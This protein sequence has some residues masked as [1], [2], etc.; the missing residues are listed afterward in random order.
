[1]ALTNENPPAGGA[2]GL[3]DDAF[4]GR[5]CSLETTKTRAPAQAKSRGG[6]APRDKGARLERALVR[7][8][9]DSGLGAER[10]PLSGAAGGSY[11]GDLTVPLLGRDLVV[12]AKSRRDGFKELY[13]WLEGRDV[14][15]VKS[16]RKEPLLVVRFRLGVE[17]AV[18]AEGRRP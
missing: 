9:Q 8:L 11:S 3:R 10:V 18:A 7:L 6:R 13:S 5:N 16:D 1:M 15:V 12:E 17:I 14:L 4:P 2:D